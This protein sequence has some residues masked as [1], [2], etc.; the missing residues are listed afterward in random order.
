MD[1]EASA[2]QIETEIATGNMSQSGTPTPEDHQ[3]QSSDTDGQETGQIEADG[4]VEP[5][6]VDGEMDADVDM[7]ATV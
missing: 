2:S 1:L 6:I 5:E 7:V 4:E 3:K